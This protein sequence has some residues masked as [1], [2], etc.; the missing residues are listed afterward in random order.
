MKRKAITALFVA[1]IMILGT[2]GVFALDYEVPEDAITVTARFSVVGAPEDAG[3]EF[4]ML[5]GYAGLTI[6]ITADTIVYFEDYVPLGD[7]EE[8][9][10]TQMAREVLFGRTLAEVLEDRNLRVIYVE[11]EENKAISIMILFETAV[12]LPQDIDLDDIDL[13]DTDLNGT[14]LEE[15]EDND[16]QGI[17]TLPGEIGVFDFDMDPILLNGEVVVNNEILENAPLPFWQ[18]VEN[19]YVAMVPLRVVAEALAYDVTWNNEL[20]SV[21]LGVGIHLWIGNTEVVVGRM[22][23]IELQVAPVIVDDL[24]FVPLNFFRDV[25]GQTVYVFEGQVVIE[26]YSDMM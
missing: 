13:D 1:A 3:E 10:M 24:T 7:D 23:P 11:G 5:S 9:G 19:G 2:V 12:H 21:Q 25:L 22:A 4:V 18:E 26:T 15:Y 14:D 6:H 20:R 8:D 16:Y 17:M